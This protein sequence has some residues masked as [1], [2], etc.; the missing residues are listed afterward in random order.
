MEQQKSQG[1]DSAMSSRLPSPQQPAQLVKKR[2]K[3]PW[4]V[5]KPD[6]FGSFFDTPAEIQHKVCVILDLFPNDLDKQK[7]ALDIEI[8]PD[9]HLRYRRSNREVI[10]RKFDDYTDHLS[11]YD[12]FVDEDEESEEEEG[13]ESEDEDYGAVKWSKKSESTADGS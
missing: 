13:V 4:V 1:Q 9:E 5:Y 8:D 6:G 12:S 7:E 11:D 2:R 3:L 10:R